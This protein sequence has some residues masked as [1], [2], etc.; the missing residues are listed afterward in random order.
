M[1]LSVTKSL[2]IALLFCI[3]CAACSPKLMKTANDFADAGN[4]LE[5][6]EQ[7]TN[8]IKEKPDY[9]EAYIKRAEAYKKLDKQEEATLDYKRAT[10]FEK[11]NSLLF[12]NTGKGF[13][14]L[15]RFEEAIP[16]LNNAIS[17][18][19][20]QT[21]P[22]TMLVEAYIALKNYPMAL[23]IANKAIDVHAESGLFY[24]HRGYI[25]LQTGSFALAEKDFLKALSFKYRD[26]DLYVNLAK[27]LVAQNKFEQA[28]TYCSNGLDM[29]ERNTRLLRLR[30]EIYHKKLDYPN[31]INDLS[32]MIIFTPD[33]SLAFFTRGVYYQEFN[34]HQS[35]INDFSKVLALAPSFAQAYY[36]RGLSYEEIT[37]YTRAVS[38]FEAYAQLERNNEEAED[39]LNEVKKRLFE[40]N[41]ENNI[42]EVAIGKPL[43][44]LPNTLDVPEGTLR[45]LIEGEVRDDSPLQY[46]KFDGQDVEWLNGGKHGQ[47]R[48][49]VILDQKQTITLAAADVYNNVLAKTFKIR[50]TEVTPPE[51][52]LVAPYASADGEVYLANDLKKL[53]IEG[54]ITDASLIKRI[55]VNDMNASYQAQK[56]NPEFFATIDIT[57]RDTF[58]VAVEDIYGNTTR[59]GYRLNRE[60]VNI[61]QENPMGKTW[62][63]FI[64]NS[65]YQTFASLEGPVKDVSMMKAAL[66]NYKIHNIIH[67]KDMSKQQMQRFFSIELRDLVRAN[68]VNSLLVWYAG[69]GK[70]LNKTGY[71]VPI[72]ATRDDEFTFYNINTLRAAL[73]SYNDVTHT[74]VITDA[75]E[76]GPTFYQAMR[77]TPKERD[78]NDWQAT[79]FKSS[80]VLSSA[81]YELAMDNS[82][83]T[84]T[85]ANSLINNPNACLPIENIVTHVTVAVTK[86][87]Q[88]K[89][90][91][92][93]IA[94]LEDEG[95]T[96]FFMTK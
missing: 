22:Y 34:Q 84:R 12:L 10:T 6:I 83:F 89:P 45:L 74:L 30:A 13:Y 90:Q 85:F 44:N 67:K 62:V 71:W 47:F 51:V 14:Q 86:S 27:S 24:Y 2:T 56:H 91:F 78:C 64:E 18:D 20:S 77:S 92:G 59:K 36:R 73:Q 16:F 79:K 94:G 53:Y 39:R 23:S 26:A 58:V 19:K 93:K 80:Q 48:V 65:N 28:L 55:M 54:Q 21:A 3:C 87:G 31:A 52:Q 81:G 75:C 35:A 96:F 5:A 50:F 15:A 42:P 9:V 57:N 76:S 1:K 38:D 11:D 49:E 46:A 33:D 68:H 4:Y 72:D 70:Y 66:A 63:I 17:L 37:D 88:Q 7:Y 82:Q 40:L 29:D 8:V 95:G 60:G 69:H 25:Q 43:S 41:R 32:K 61:A